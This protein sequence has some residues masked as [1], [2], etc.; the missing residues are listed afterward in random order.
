MD[1]RYARL[2]ARVNRANFT[3]LQLHYFVTTA[4]RRSMTDAA[5]DLHVA[6]SAVST[7]IAQ[8]ERSLGVQLFVRQHSRGVALTDAGVQLLRDARPLLA[9]VDEISDAVRGQQYDVRGTLRLACFI[10]LAPFVLPRLISRVEQEHPRLH[11][12]IIESDVDSTTQML[13]DGTV[14]AAI[15]YEFAPIPGLTFERLYRAPP[16]VIVSATHPLAARDRLRLRDLDGRD[17][18]LLDIPRSR[19]YFL[20]MLKS[21]GVEP[22]IRYSSHSYETVRSLVAQ[23]HGFS[24]LNNIPRSPVTYDGKE[25]RPVPI[26]DDVP[27]LDVCLARVTDVRPT[28]RARI[29]AE[30]ARD[31]FGG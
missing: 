19:E 22:S 25:L 6:Q 27:A 1:S 24:I 28:A 12:E 26:A 17:M 15:A 10:T 13:L 29:I 3:L 14:E 2:M 8:L 20:G 30:L 31:L 9:Q 5:L 18:V 4:A 23:G 11:V 7:A 21:A 16:H